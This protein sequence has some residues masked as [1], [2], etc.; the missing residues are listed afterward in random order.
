MDETTKNVTITEELNER[1]GSA[2]EEVTTM[3]QETGTDPLKAAIESQLR[4]VQRQNLLLG[5]QTIL[6]TV[7]E[8]IVK[9]ENQPGKRTMNDYRRLIKDLKHFC[10]VGLSRKVN[11][12]G[13]TEPVKE[14]SAMEETVQN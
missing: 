8:K 11:L 10:E 1:T 14:D 3:D 13:E 9:A 4:K 2:E 6:H 12:D 5:A 7:L